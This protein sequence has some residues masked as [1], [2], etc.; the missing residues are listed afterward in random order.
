MFVG[1][2][3]NVSCVNM[4][5]T[6]VSGE[7]DW[8]WWSEL[9]ETDDGI[10][11]LSDPVKLRSSR[12]LWEKWFQKLVITA[13]ITYS[14]LSFPPLSSLF[15]LVPFYICLYLAAVYSQTSVPLPPSLWLLLS[16]SVWSNGNCFFYYFFPSVFPFV[17]QISFFLDCPKPFRNWTTKV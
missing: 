4:Q 10:L 6:H 3:L 7:K 12:A 17:N 9:S 13:L 15:P 11:G 8:Q 2:E 1:D 14:A 5:L 16:S